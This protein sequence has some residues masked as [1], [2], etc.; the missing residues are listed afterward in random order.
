[1]RSRLAARSARLVLAA[2]TVT[3][4]AAT[5]TACG[6]E[7]DGATDSAAT[8]AATSGSS[9]G[10]STTGGSGDSGSDS[11]SKDSGSKDSG[12]GGS[13]SKDS[14]SS[15]SAGGSDDPKKDGY[16]QSCGNNDVDFKVTVETQAGGYYLVTAKAKPGITCTLDVNTPNVSFGSRTEGIASPIGQG[17]EPPIKLTGSAVAYAGINPKTTE[18]VDNYIEFESVIISLSDDDPDPVEIKLPDTAQIDK[19]VV[20]NWNKEIAGAVPNL[21]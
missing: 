20:T 15:D 17:G 13:G 14:G 2:A 11:G 8:S 5:M 16:G 10:S 19:P 9:G 18:D 4:L 12:S 3:A 1:M 21:V 7:E 6:P